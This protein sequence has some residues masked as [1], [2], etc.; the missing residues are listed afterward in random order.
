M[1]VCVCVC[2]YVLRL[3]E[4]C[5]QKYSGSVQVV[6]SSTVYLHINLHMKSVCVCPVYKKQFSDKI[7]W[8]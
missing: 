1:T 5:T 7:R 4:L 8:S 2:V 6:Y 3:N